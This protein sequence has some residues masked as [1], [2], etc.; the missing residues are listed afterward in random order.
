MKLAEAL[1]LRSDLQKRFEQVKYRLNNNVKI[2]EGEQPAE[3]PAELLKEMDSLLGQLGL[4][5]Q[6][7]NRT[8]NTVMLDDTRTLADALV[9]RDMLSMRRTALADLAQ[10]ASIRQDRFTRSEVRFVSIVNVAELQREA[11]Q[12]AKTYRELDTRIQG[13]NWLTD[14]LV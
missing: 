14:L 10:S 1:I 7:I 9:D 12:L 5:I 3:Q 4:L 6:Q 13:M 11:D 2:Q 8:N